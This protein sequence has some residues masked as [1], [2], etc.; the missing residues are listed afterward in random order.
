MLAGACGG[1][2]G[3]GGLAGAAKGWVGLWR[4]GKFL[5]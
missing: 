4:A 5:T 1:W 2:Q 3:L